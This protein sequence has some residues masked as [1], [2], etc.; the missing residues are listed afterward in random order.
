M[1]RHNVYFVS[2]AKPTKN[3]IE[4]VS[5]IKI[6]FIKYCITTSMRDIKSSLDASKDMLQGDELTLSSAP[7][8]LS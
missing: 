1:K 8:M 3:Q 4:E 2:C 7:E 6:N 5:S